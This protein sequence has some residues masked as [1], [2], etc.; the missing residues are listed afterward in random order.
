MFIPF[1]YYAKK[2]LDLV[3]IQTIKK[4]SFEIETFFFIILKVHS[5]FKSKK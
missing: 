5:P 4:T 2:V 1:Y 3:K